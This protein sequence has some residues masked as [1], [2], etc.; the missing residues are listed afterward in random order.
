[1]DWDA[2]IVAGRAEVLGFFMAYIVDALT[3]LNVVDQTGNVICKAALLFTIIGILVVR[4]KEDIDNKQKLDDEATFYDK[5]W[6]ASWQSSD[7]INAVKEQS[8]KND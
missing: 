2:V 7:A 3:G 6:Q 4:R 5:Q 8:N 1:M